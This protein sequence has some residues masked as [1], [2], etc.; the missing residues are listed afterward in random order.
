MKKNVEIKPIFIFS[1]PR[2]GSTLLQRVLATHDEISTA[3]EPWLLLPF[4]YAL[5]KEGTYAEYSHTSAQ[6]AVRDFCKE[7]PGGEHDYLSAVRTVMLELYANAAISD[8]VYFLDK[9]PR[10]A[11]VSEDILRMFSGDSKSIF[12]W[13]NPLAIIASM[14]ESFNDGKW[15][16]FHSKIDLYDGMERLIQA[17]EE[18]SSTVMSVK[19]ES[20]VNEPVD[21]LLRITEFLQIEYK[22]SAVDFFSDVKF[23]GSMGDPVGVKEY[24]KISSDSLDKWKKTL[25]SP[26]RKAWCRRYLCWLGRGRLEVMGYDLDELLDELNQI[27]SQWLEVIPDIFRGVYGSLYCLFEFKIAKDKVRNLLNERR[28]FKHE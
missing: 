18:N 26:V 16:I 10:Y 8:A 2:S 22:K 12:L 9:T 19:Y 14:I 4:L 13:R 28:I 24:N 25:A 5:K 27:P 17:Y 7:L 3:A 23:Q 1:L 11:L 21:T 20:L 15:Y 6:I